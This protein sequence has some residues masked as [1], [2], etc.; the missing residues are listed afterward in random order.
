MM[1]S[2]N[3]VHVLWGHRM[4]KKPGNHF[5]IVIFFFVAL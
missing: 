5:K 1:G 4:L 2:D 3:T